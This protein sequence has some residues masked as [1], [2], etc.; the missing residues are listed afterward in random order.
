MLGSLDPQQPHG[1]LATVSTDAA[2]SVAVS[3]RRWRKQGRTRGVTFLGICRESTRWLALLM[4]SRFPAAGVVVVAER[5][6]PY[7]QERSRFEN[8]SSLSAPSPPAEECSRCGTESRDSTPGKLGTRPSA[9]AGPRSLMSSRLT[10]QST[11]FGPLCA[12]AASGRSRRCLRIIP[13][14]DYEA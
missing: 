7:A 11:C 13:D 1:Q 9:N 3:P 8:N 5:R 6:S 4:H 10:V 14:A 2:K 12:F